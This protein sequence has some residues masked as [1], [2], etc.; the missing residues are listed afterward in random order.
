MHILTSHA[1]GS[2]YFQGKNTHTHSQTQISN[3]HTH[4]HTQKHFSNG[5]LVS[6]HLR[7]TKTKISML[8]LTTAIATKYYQVL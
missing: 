2:Y 8:Q 5:T 1:K 6:V 7:F 3:V 4:T